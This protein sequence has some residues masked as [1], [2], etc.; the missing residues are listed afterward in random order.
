IIGGFFVGH[1]HPT[2]VIQL[3]LGVVLLLLWFFISGRKNISD[4]G[5]I[6]TGR[7]ARFGFNATLY[8]VVFVGVLSCI[9]WIG[10]RERFKK[11]WDLTEEG[12]YSLSK[13]TLKVLDSLKE[14]LKIVVFNARG[15]ENR[16]FDKIKLYDYHS[17]KVS[18]EIVDPNAKPYLLKKY[19][20]K[21]GNR[22]YLGYGKDENSLA[23]SRINETT[24]EAIT[25]AII[26]LT[27]GAAKKIYYLVGHGEPNIHSREQ[28]GFQL[29]ADA[30]EDEHM[31]LEELNLAQKGSV[32]NDAAAVIVISPK[33]PMFEQEK[34]AIIEYAEKGGRLFLMRDPTYPVNTTDVQDIARHFGIVIRDDL[35]LDTVMR[36][37]AGPSMDVQFMAASFRPHPITRELS[38][39]DKP[40]FN[41]TSSV[42]IDEDNKLKGKYT[43]LFMSS[44]QSWGESDLKTVFTTS[45]PTVSKGDDD[46]AG[47]LALAMAFE[48]DVNKGNDKDKGGDK[49]ENKNNPGKK[50][51]VIVFGDSDWASNG[52]FKFSVHRDLLL[53]SLNWLIGEESSISIRPA[54]YKTSLTRLPRETFYIILGTGFFVPELVLLFGLAVWWRRRVE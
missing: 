45:N 2:M 24:E 19:G 6:V 26:K 33:T 44:P 3:V 29:M 20:I 28:T 51:R 53:N 49:A 52:L 39:R 18:V 40:I 37:F 27:K 30:I 22:V 8:G 5:R 11:R 14:P 41:L 10:Y 17:D 25:N 16:D 36:L 35:V 43:K 50:I 15:N 7:T 38:P 9:N 1:D 47:P 42:D 32:P 21:G 23:E 34:Q 12:V 13:Q 54:K 48:G 4:A 46:N 31:K